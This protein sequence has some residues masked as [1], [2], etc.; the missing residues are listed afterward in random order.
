MVENTDYFGASYWG[1]SYWGGGYFGSG[2]VVIPPVITPT[3]QPTTYGTAPKFP[4]SPLTVKYLIE[5]LKL[6]LDE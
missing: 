6:K 1:G 4:L 5:Y 3:T 2:G